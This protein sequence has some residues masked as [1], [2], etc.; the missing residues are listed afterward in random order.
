MVTYD[1]IILPKITI[2]FLGDK[3]YVISMPVHYKHSRDA[4]R[5]IHNGR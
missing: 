4:K 5:V 3:N 1:N 2:N